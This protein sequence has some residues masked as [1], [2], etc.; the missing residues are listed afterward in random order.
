MV[1]VYIFNV[2]EFSNVFALVLLAKTSSLVWLNH[3]QHGL[4]MSDDA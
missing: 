3:K 1:V 2:S 4:L